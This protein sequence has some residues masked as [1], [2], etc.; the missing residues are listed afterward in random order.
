MKKTV[1]GKLLLG[2]LAVV[3]VCVIIS[4]V[5]DHFESLEGGVEETEYEVSPPTLQ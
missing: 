2:L 3:A 4:E 5:S 1:F